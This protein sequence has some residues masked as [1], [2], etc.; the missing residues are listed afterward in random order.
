MEEGIKTDNAR[1][2]RTKNMAQSKYSAARNLLGVIAVLFLNACGP[3]AGGIGT[4]SLVNAS[5]N[6]G[7][8]AVVGVI[9]REI[10]IGTWISLDSSTSVNFTSNS[11]AITSD[12]DQFV[13]GGN[14]VLDDGKNIN[15]QTSANSVAITFSDTRM[16]FV[17]RDSAGNL[18]V[19]AVALTKAPDSTTD[20]L[21]GCPQ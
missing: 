8:D 15:R 21:A 18:I 16:G 19:S 3:G 17:V 7:V 13:F 9:A 14:W 20:P 1:S 12:C 6:G 11:I 4:G 2:A 5:V 10:I